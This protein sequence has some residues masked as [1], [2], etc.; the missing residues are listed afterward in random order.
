MEI[1][2]NRINP[3]QL[4]SP[5][6]QDNGKVSPGR[7]YNDG[8]DVTESRTE[9]PGG[10]SEFISRGEVIRE[11]SGPDYAEM[12][13]RARLAQAYGESQGRA[14]ETREPLA[15][16]KAL[17]AYQNHAAPLESSGVE[18]LPRVDDYV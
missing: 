13:Q 2:G 11:R 15:I 18:L 9:G 10:L 4:P 7:R 16:Q 3:Y 12:L 8:K 14:Y 17:D 1:S 5:E 6:R